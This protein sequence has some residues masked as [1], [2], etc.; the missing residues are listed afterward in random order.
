MTPVDAA[1]LLIDGPWRHRFVTANGS[2]FHVAVAGPEDREAPL[3]VLLHGIW[4]FWW[5]WRFQIPALA[6]AGY[7]V[8]AVDLRGSG[9]SD[10]PPTGYDVPTQ[11][12]DVSAVI[13]SLGAQQAVVIG[14]GTGG[15]IA[16]A[17][18]AYARRTVTAVGTLAAPRSIT[19]N[20]RPSWNWQHNTTDLVL[21]AQLPGLPERSLAHGDLLTRFINRWAGSTAWP[22]SQ[23]AKMHQQAIRVPFA[24]HSQLEQ[25]RWLVRSVPRAD[26][27]RYRAKLLASPAVPVLQ[28]HGRYDGFRTATALGAK[29]FRRF[30]TSYHF[31]TVDDA[32][33]F[34][35]EQQPDAVNKLLLDWLYN[36]Y[37]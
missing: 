9:A 30:A 22:D 24:A 37:H 14:S 5:S 36:L 2:R 28:I 25:L 4:G 17:A 16:W 20:G 10:K 19:G 15:D 7:R 6:A 27:A 23:T 21:Y 33:Y 11:V 1:T 12:A 31:E 18:Q 13:R 3:V 8:A 35:A 34:M 32:G 29:E 26:G